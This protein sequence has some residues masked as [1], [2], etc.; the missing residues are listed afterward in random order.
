M[1][2]NA[3]AANIIKIIELT[4]FREFIPYGRC[5]ER[6][7][8]RR[9]CNKNS[10]PKRKADCAAKQ[11][12]DENQTYKKPDKRIHQIAGDITYRVQERLVGNFPVEGRC[13][14]ECR[15]EYKCGDSCRER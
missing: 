8:D 2:T 12:Y 14:G 11:Q 1:S 6:K 15:Q 5:N 3:L 13:E 9:R 7:R 10:C 4:A